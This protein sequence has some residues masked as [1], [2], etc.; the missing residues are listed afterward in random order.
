MA[1]A[2]DCFD[3]GGK[4]G[5]PKRS[6]TCADLSPTRGAHLLYLHVLRLGEDAQ[7][8]AQVGVGDTEE[9]SELAELGIA[10]GGQQGA[11]LQAH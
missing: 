5:S 3:V 10:G 2:L 11:E 1:K 4:R 9:V 6:Q 7:L 8:F